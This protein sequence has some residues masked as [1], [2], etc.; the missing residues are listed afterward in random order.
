MELN[1]SLHPTN[2]VTN[3]KTF[4]WKK[5]FHEYKWG[6]FFVAPMFILFVIFS[7]IPVIRSIM[8]AFQNYDGSWGI[9]NFQWMLG[10]RVF[11]IALKNTLIYTLVI[12]PKNLLLALILASIIQPFSNKVQTFFRT[13]FYLPA[14]T[15]A[16]VFSLIWLWILN[17]EMGFLNHLLG[18]F[19]LQKIGWLTNPDIALWGII[20]TDFVLAPGSGIILYLA[21]MNG[22]PK[23]L[24]EAAEIDGAGFFAKWWYITVPLVKSTTLY[25]LIVYMI[26]SFQVFTKINIMTNGGPGNSTQTIVKLIYDSAFKDYDWGYASAQAL[27]LFVIIG[28]I[29]LIQFKFFSNDVEY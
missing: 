3:K 10:D 9:E 12:V 28:I 5:K 14:V 11:W 18:V 23:T 15:S 2:L 6:Y 8:L 22:I 13:A 25:L 1:N 7:F 17:P 16:V 4:K 24:Y 20:F 26:G 21:A 27:V 29:S 19:G